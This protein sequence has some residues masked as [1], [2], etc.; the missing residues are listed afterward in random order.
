MPHLNV[1]RNPRREWRDGEPVRALYKPVQAATKIFLED[2]VAAARTYLGAKSD[3]LL[4]KVFARAKYLE[5]SAKRT[6]A[7]LMGEVMRQRA[8]QAMEQAGA[9]AA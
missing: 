4:G 3:A 2:G 7:A 8:L 6:E 1:G 5:R 9:P